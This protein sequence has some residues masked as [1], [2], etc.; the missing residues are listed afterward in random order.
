MKAAVRRLLPEELP[1]FSMRARTPKANR[2]KRKGRH[3]TIHPDLLRALYP[4]LY[5][6]MRVELPSYIPPTLVSVLLGTL[7]PVGQCLTNRP[8][9]CGAMMNSSLCY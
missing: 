9:R 5:N 8:G 7:E 1:L 2:L 3:H 4:E 6:R